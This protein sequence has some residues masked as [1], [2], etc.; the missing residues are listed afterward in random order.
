MYDYRK[1][2]PEE[3]LE[4][5]RERKERGY[6]LHSPPHYKG[7]EGIYL[8]TAT[9]Y[10]HHSV[11][12]TFDLLSLLRDTVLNRFTNAES[13][14]SAWVFLP[15][16]YHILLNTPDLTFVGEALRKA[17]S[18]TAAKANYM[19]GKQGRRVWYRY[20]D[21]MMRSERHYWATVNYI[22][23]NPIKHGYVDNMSAWPWSSVHD[24]WDSLGEED[25][26]QKWKQYPIRDYGKGWDW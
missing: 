7:I 9:C 22:H 12:D 14:Y 16:H 13:P 23:Y 20:S 19:Q 6:P 26:R 3:C 10:E 18:R 4:V 11:F 17:H 1:M 24:Y 21:R 8:I 15:T 5:L 2:T 25:M